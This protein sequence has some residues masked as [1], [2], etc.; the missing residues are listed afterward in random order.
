MS[1][2]VVRTI[3][4]VNQKGGVGKCVA[5]D[6]PIFLNPGEVK[7]IAELF[8]AA[9]E[10][11]AERVVRDGGV[12]IRPRQP[13]R[14]FSLDRNLK[15]ARAQVEWLYRGRAD[16]LKCITTAM[17]KTI[18]VTKEHPF[19]V[20][21]E[22]EL[23]WVRADEL[24]IGDF[25]ATPRSV[26]ETDDGGVD[27]L[28]LLPSEILAHLS[29]EAEA[30]VQR[31]LTAILSL[32][33]DYSACILRALLGRPRTRI[34]LDGISTQSNRYRILRQFSKEGIITRTRDRRSGFRYTADPVAATQWVLRCGCSVRAVAQFPALKPFV[35]HLQYCNRFGHICPPVAP[36]F[37]LT[38][39][40]ARFVAIV[41][42]EGSVDP[43]RIV[44]YNCSSFLIEDVRAFA[45]SCGLTPR[46]ERLPTQWR[47][48]I[49]GAG[50]LVQILEALCE[51]DVREKRKSA[52][53]KLPNCILQAP[54][55]LLAPYLGAY[56][57]CEGSVSQFKSEI[58]ITSASRDNIIRLQYAFLRFGVPSAVRMSR[59][60][61]TNSPR[62]KK[63]KYWRLE[64]RG[65]SL[66]KKIYEQIPLQDERKRTLLARWS[67]GKA[68]T[69]IDLIPAGRLIHSLRIGG[70]LLQKEIGLQGS[71][72]DYERGRS[73]PSRDALQRIVKQLER[74]ASSRA[75][76]EL[77]A[78]ADADILWD[79]VKEVREKHNKGYVY[80]LTV[81]GSHNFIAGWGAFIAHN[82]TTAVNLS[83]YLAH[84]GKF[85]LLVDLDPQGN[86]T[87][88]FGVDHHAQPE[89]IYE[90]LAGTAPLK[91]VMRAT[92]IEGH[93]LA[94]ASAALAGATIELV[95]LERREH[96]L[97]DTLEEAG[98]EF[99][100]IIIDCPPSLGLLTVNAL[101]GADEVLIPV[102]AE[103]YALE[104]LG[105]L[106]ETISLVRENLNPGLG[107]LGAL[108]TMYDERYKLTHDVFHELYRYFPN[109]IFRTVIP[110]N[111]RLA[112]APSYGKTILHYDPK[113]KGARAY[114]KLAKEVIYTEP[115]VDANRQ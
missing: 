21:R 70:D 38:E 51:F 92:T 81:P 105:G 99:D 73:F 43:A 58:E 60:R 24:N 29:P 106:M 41:L 23:A 78:L 68:N 27:L 11:A 82:T 7:S 112:E 74:K 107:V 65:A 67:E 83:A 53:V 77:A 56:I 69:N 63:R 14:V 96:R 66:C 16:R 40:F 93:K 31:H 1:S 54:L 2:S 46:V 9:N 15:I 30:I 109:R 110:R 87:S 39:A 59:Q 48:T 13:L 85:V 49:P 10:D 100:Y 22:G 114:E 37:E 76:I 71:I 42:A 113:S 35:Q 111:I 33:S 52:Q 3:A 55:L 32:A 8:Q 6:T 19:L 103:Y 79:R 90:S 5:P 4:I 26:P 50:T 20:C 75:H 64:I 47:V 45:V 72:S 36:M 28:A 104:G 84:L 86:A 44:V 95:N 25:L 108:I 115:Y 80:D 18:S 97:R 12:Y 101:V 17:G 91:Q 57:D 94:P 89:G 102:Q 88:A 34:E 62:M 61:A 98:H